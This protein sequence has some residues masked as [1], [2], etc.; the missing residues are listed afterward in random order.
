MGHLA[1]DAQRGR[2]LADHADPGYRV[3]IRRVGAARVV[4]DHRVE[5]HVG[6]PD[7]LESAETG[8][9]DG[10]LT[11]AV[12]V[13][14]PESQR[15]ARSQGEDHQRRLLL[16]LEEVEGTVVEDRAVLVDLHQ[17]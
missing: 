9:D 15:L 7:H 12:G 1:E 5:P 3:G 14:D 17:R 13:T 8:G 4:A 2:A 11:D 6:R 16:V 10:V